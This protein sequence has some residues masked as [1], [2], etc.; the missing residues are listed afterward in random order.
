VQHAQQGLR[1]QPEQFRAFVGHLFETLKEQ[2]LSID[3]S[4]AIVA[5]V[6][7]R[8]DDVFSSGI[9]SCGQAAKGAG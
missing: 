3:E 1:I 4:R 2:D 8:A 5:R 7:A 6:N 9:A